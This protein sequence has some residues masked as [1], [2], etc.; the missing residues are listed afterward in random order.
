MSL[1]YYHMFLVGFHSDRSQFSFVKRVSTF[2]GVL[3]PSL[4]PQRQPS[5]EKKKYHCNLITTHSLLTI[6]NILVLKKVLFL[7]NSNQ[8]PNLDDPASIQ[9]HKSTKKQENI[10]Q[11]S[12]EGRGGRRLRRLLKDEEEARCSQKEESETWGCLSQ[13][14]ASRGCVSRCCVS[15]FHC[16]APPKL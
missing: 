3:R 2:R 15:R 7:K 16:C 13:C 5:R 14:C 9:Q 12:E 1:G 4:M 8:Q 6:L 11:C 10:A